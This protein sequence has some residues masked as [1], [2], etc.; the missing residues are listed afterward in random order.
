VNPRP[1]VLR[2]SAPFHEAEI[3]LDRDAAHALADTVARGGDVP[4]DPAADPKPYE[5]LLDALHVAV[6]PEGKVV[7]GLDADERVLTVTGAA[8]HL[9]VL[10]DVVLDLADDPDPDA[11]AHVEYFDEHYYLAESTVSLVL[12]IVSE[13]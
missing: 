6:V 11:H 10:A 1:P 12:R 4:A 3:A 5:R 13:A 7:L 9:A 8:P 2:Y